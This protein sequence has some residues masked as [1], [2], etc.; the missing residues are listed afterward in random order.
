[1]KP[2]TTRYLDGEIRAY[3]VSGSVYGP[4]DPAATYRVETFDQ[5]LTHAVAP[6]LDR[7][8]YITS[9]NVVCISQNSDLLWHYDLGPHNTK[10]YVQDARCVFSL[11]GAWVWVY[12]PDAMADRGPDLLVILQADTGEEVARRKLDSVGEGASLALHPDGRHVLLDVGEGQDGVK[13]YRAVLIGDDINL[14]SYGWDDRALI[15][16]APDGRWFM[17]VDHGRYDVA[18][19]VFPRGEVALRLPIEAF[20]YEYSGDDEA[21]L[22]WNGGFLNADIAV[23]TIA[24]E[25]DDKEWH[26]HYSVNLRTGTPIGRFETYSRDNYDFEP[27]GD[28]TWIVSGPDGSSVHRYSTM[29][30]GIPNSNIGR[31]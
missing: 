12:L 2:T 15:D 3:R 21:H 5:D 22:D 16:V 23:V 29:T 31:D 27:L 25:K 10:R 18:F 26:H 20:G 9:D 6:N 13:L 28:G 8:V 4:L 19:H 1:M 24:G 11:D 7:A 30:Q 14:Y 17:T